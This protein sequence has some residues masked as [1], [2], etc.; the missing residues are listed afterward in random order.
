M[1]TRS[2]SIYKYVS[3]S[4]TMKQRNQPKVSDIQERQLTDG[5]YGDAGARCCIRDGA[6]LPPAV[7]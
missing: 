7:L 6:D 4:A 2:N 3:G 5:A 1:N